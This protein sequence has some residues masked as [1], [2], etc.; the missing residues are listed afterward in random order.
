[1]KIFVINLDKRQD[2]L[3][4]ITAELK[5]YK[6]ER[7]SAV[8]GT[9][10]TVAEFEEEDFF[11]LKEWRDPLLKRPLTLT[12]VACAV[13]H[14]K[15]WEICAQIEQNILI[16]ED[17][18]YLSSNL[19][20]E[21]I[22]K[23]LESYDLVYLHHKEM[24]PEQE[25]QINSE[26]VKPYYPYLTTS[27]ALTPALAKRLIKS[28]YNRSIIPVDEFLPCVLGVDY[29]NHSLSGHTRELLNDLQKR[30]SSVL[31]VK[32]AAYKQS[33]F[34]QHS[35]DKFGSDIE[36]GKSIMDNET[37]LHLLTVGTDESKTELLQK[38]ADRFGY[39]FKN[40]G[41]NMTWN[42]GD[43]ITPG[44]G[45]KINLVKKEINSLP[46]DDI[47]FFADGYDVIVNDHI[48]NIIGRFFE[49][50]CD[51]L[52]AA[53]PF[54][55][56]KD[57]LAEKY[58]A[59]ETRY[60]FLNSG[61]YIGRVGSLKHILRM[62]IH[63]R[64]DDQEYFTNRFLE[65]LTEPSYAKIKLD[66]E[67][68]IFQC[69]NGSVDS[70]GIKNNGQLI[71]KETNCCPCVLHGNGGDR[72][73][74]ILK[75]IYERLA[76]EDKG[77]FI[78]SAKVTD[79]GQ[80]FLTIPFMTSEMCKWLVNEAE[81]KG[82]WESMYGDKFPGQEVRIRSFSMD[83]WNALENHF[84]EV[85]NPQI[86]KYWFPLLMY[87]LRDAFVIKYSPGTQ[88]RLHCHHDASLVSGIIRLND[89]YE[90]GETYF[91]R[92][93]FSNINIPKGTMLL[94]P[95]QVTHGH[96]GKPVTKGTKYSL[97]IWTARK[98]GDVNY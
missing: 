30:F 21:S 25:Q 93:K 55:W 28:G 3:R 13:S 34:K 22:E 57:S 31:P 71:N 60:R 98:P 10:L 67:N 96:E 90:G 46:N 97:V 5:N 74:D 89:E 61:L 17:D 6:W 44:G 20:L 54:C 23:N 51:V 73:K 83:F 18:A 27:Y 33:I 59:T 12:E 80:E 8:D 62:E 82:K 92:Q 78:R 42:G 16:V 4:S 68:Y 85:I 14:F 47:V 81:T 24:V 36:M 53:E 95:G 72:M 26:L 91:Y 43:M 66:T 45:Q 29:F 56:P 38:S 70:I 9:E 79:L 86:E 69:L 65:S 63:D 37:K 50:D 35:R 19:D 48:N 84:K 41:L 76:P 40:L 11:P 58:P 15:L 52:F 87:E 7:F 39:S 32:A 64:Q 49:F 88:D 2:R 77:Y 94:W 1:M 75:S